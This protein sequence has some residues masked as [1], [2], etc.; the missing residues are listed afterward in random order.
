MTA[1]LYHHGIEGQKWG[2]RNGPPYPLDESDRSSAERAANPPAEKN[3]YGGSHAKRPVGEIS[4]RELQDY[5]SRLHMERQYADLTR[6]PDQLLSNVRK[7]NTW[8][9]EVSSASESIT[10]IL[11]F[12]KTVKEAF[13]KKKQP[14]AEDIETAK[15]MSDE[16][17][18]N[19]VNRRDLEKRYLD[20]RG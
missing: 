10:K 4:D 7:V 15:S 17:L 20:A 9:K 2:V 8:L 18:R 12:T 1:E 3:S 16:D 11:N 5:I 6:E 19:Y 13:K 14:S